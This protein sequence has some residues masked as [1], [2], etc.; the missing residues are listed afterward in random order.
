MTIPLSF[1]HANTDIASRLRRIMMNSREFARYSP[2][3]PLGREPRSRRWSLSTTGVSMRLLV[4]LLLTTGWLF[5]QPSQPKNPMNDGIAAFKDARYADAVTEFE[6]AVQVSPVDP[7]A[8]LYLATALM[9]QF[10]PGAQSP[11]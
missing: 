5:A 2:G 7:T 1:S 9:S 10:I 4:T 6:K 3:R 11:E 8:Q